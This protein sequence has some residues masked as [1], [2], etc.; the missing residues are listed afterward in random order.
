[1][2]ASAYSPSTT[3]RP[4]SFDRYDDDI[5]HAVKIYW[6]ADFDD[7]K[8]WKAQLYQESLLDPSAVSPVGAIGLAQFMPA[9]WNDISR[10]LGWSGVSATQADAAIEAG[11]FYMARLRRGWSA[12]RPSLDRHHLAEASYN[13]G[14]GSI[15]K[16]QA[17]CGGA[18]NWPQISPCLALVTG[19]LSQQTLDYITRIDHWREQLEH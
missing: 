2:L 13:A 15:L 1:M 3:S 14:T 17:A 4:L 19:A 8:Y 11:A 9:T 5:R 12:P 18:T 10:S 7:W 16:A 6:K